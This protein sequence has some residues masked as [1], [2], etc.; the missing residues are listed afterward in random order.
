MTLIV[1]PAQTRVFSFILKALESHGRP[2]TRVEICKE[3]GYK[4]AN[5]A[6]E[7]LRALARKGLIRLIPSISRG[8]EVIA[9]KPTSL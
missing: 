1:T 5:A 9:A 7:H 4:S 8:I 2:P 3:F 6:E